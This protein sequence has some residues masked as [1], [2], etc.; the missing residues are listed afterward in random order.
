MPPLHSQLLHVCAACGTY[1]PPGNNVCRW[2]GSIRTVRTTLSQASIIAQRYEALAWQAQAAADAK[3]E[4][5]A[6]H[7]QAAWDAKVQQ[8]AQDLYG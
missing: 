3:D 8:E 1:V 4:Y 2:C 6:Q 7:G 5:I